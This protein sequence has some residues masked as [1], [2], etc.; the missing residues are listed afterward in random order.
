MIINSFKSPNFSTKL[1]KKRSIK[2]VIIH[3]TGMQSIGESIKRL[4]DIKKKVS[5]HYAI[6]REGKV[7]QLV[8][9][10]KI[11][12][13]A[14]KSKWGKFN[15]LN[16]ISIG[17]ELQN[18]GHKL[19]YQNFSGKQISS[20][21][22]LGK[23]LKKKYKLKSENFLGHSDIAPLR[24]IDP[25]EKFPW[26]KLSKYKIG[27]WYFKNKNVSKVHPKKMQELFFKNLKKLGYKYFNLRKRNFKEK[28]VIK[29]FQQR[30]LPNNLT[31]RVD[32]KTFN[33]SQF[34]TH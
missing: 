15:N 29:S 9:E 30:Y 20:L 4:C 7:Y 32:Q 17:I 1:R 22:I 13:H 14:G 11:A 10:L 34:L 8:D 12:W 23:K 2:F 27:K 26:K 19:G 24:K 16:N 21:I 28:K 31:E 5:S 18:K 33:I 6:D 3:Y 25:G